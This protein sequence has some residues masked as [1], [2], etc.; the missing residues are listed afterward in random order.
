MDY[1]AY[2]LRI[3]SSIAL[4]LRTAPEPDDGRP[5][6]A[7]VAVRIGATPVRLPNLVADGRRRG[8]CAWEAAPDT[9]LMTVD[10]RARYLVTAMD[11]TSWPSCVAGP[12]SGRHG[13]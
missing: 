10:D 3:R 12:T 13:E 11:A 8:N 1:V 9:L 4:P 6:G 5:A 2:D 7:D